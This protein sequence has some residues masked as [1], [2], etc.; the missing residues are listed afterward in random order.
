MFDIR[1]ESGEL[2]VDY[3]TKVCKALNDLED[4]LPAAAR[5]INVADVDPVL[6]ADVN[7]QGLPDAN[8]RTTLLN[9]QN[10]GVT[11]ALNHVGLQIFVA[12]MKS[13]YRIDLVKNMPVTLAE[14]YQRA[15]D[16]ER[17]LAE[18]KKTANFV[19]VQAV[20]APE[21]TQ[22]DLE[23]ELA[24]IQT[25]LHNFKTRG[26]SR[27]RGGCGG[28]GGQGGGQQQQQPKQGQQ[29]Q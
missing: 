29:Q 28:R 16:L 23:I 7:F 8:V 3:H 5:A 9:A 10:G 22:D 20:A 1:Q 15:L 19:S 17:A 11:A 12:N 21:E 6:A 14:A 27:G 13:A 18:P 24:A 25:K 4:L 26:Q 2:I